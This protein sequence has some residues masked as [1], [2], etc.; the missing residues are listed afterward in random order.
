MLLEGNHTLNIIRNNKTNNFFQKKLNAFKFFNR[1]NIN[2]MYLNRWRF[3]RFTK[4]F[5]KYN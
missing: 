5:L 2:Y 4:K 3:L 1:D